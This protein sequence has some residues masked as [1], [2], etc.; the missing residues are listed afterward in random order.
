MDVIF[1]SDSPI[2]I[3]KGIGVI[4]HKKTT[5]EDAYDIYLEEKRIKR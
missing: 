5:A 4:V 2:G 3:A 1:H